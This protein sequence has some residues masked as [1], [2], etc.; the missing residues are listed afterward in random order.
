[1]ERFSGLLGIIVILSLAYLISTNRRAIRPRIV[2]LGVAAQFFFAWIVLRFS[3]GQWAL[4]KAGKGVGHLLLGIDV[5]FWDP[6]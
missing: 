1:M 4:D 5:C 3:W 2:L 6:R